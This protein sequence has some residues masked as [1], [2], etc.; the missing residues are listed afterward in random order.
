MS[1]EKVAAQY[2]QGN[3]MERIE[4]ALREAGK[5]PANPTVEDLA[6]I[7]HFHTLGFRATTGLAD[8][9]GLKGGEEVLDVGCGLGGPARTLA[10]V[11][12]CRVTGV[13]IT[14]EYCDA[15]AELNRRVGLQDRI[16]IQEA[17][18][19]ALPFEDR[20]FDVVWTMHVSMNIADK[21]TLYDQ[22]ARVLKPGGKLAFFDLLSGEGEVHFPMPWADEPSI[23]HLAS[24]DETRLL[25][26]TAG[27]HVE[28]WEDVTA[29][30]AEFF[31]GLVKSPLGPHLLLKD[32]PG[33]MQNLGRDLKE[34]RLRAIRSVSRV[35]RD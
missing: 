18:A 15:A 25:L 24:V 4:G 6:P 23:S 34:G 8:A 3:L 9:A 27:L 10:S 12:G 22:F 31:S 28:L 11:Y 21:A 2:T 35:E 30:G 1:I 5:D 29:E 16:V 32:M 26:S 19:L 20:T 14:A 7:D 17:N 33:K 13:D